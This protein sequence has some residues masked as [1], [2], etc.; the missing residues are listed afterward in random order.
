MNRE[1]FD[2]CCSTYEMLVADPAG[3]GSRSIY[4]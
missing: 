4:A 1:A 2:V 3:F